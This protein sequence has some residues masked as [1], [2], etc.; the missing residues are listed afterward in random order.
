M[1][2][3]REGIDIITRVKAKLLGGVTQ[4]LLEQTIQTT[5]EIIGRR[6]DDFRDTASEIIIH[7]NRITA[8]KAGIPQRL[9]L[10]NT[11]T[12]QWLRDKGISQVDNVKD[13]MGLIHDELK[14][15]NRK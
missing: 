14:K 13:A 12:V 11:S 2:E 6:H 10:D 8:L 7:A 9:V 1:E 3:N 5:G 15:D 4:R